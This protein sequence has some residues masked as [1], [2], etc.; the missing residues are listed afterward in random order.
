MTRR[1]WD[2]LV[3]I[4]VILA[5]KVSHEVTHYLAAVGLGERVLAFRFLTNGWG[6]SQ[7][8]YATPV[9]ERAGAYWLVIALAPTLVTVLIGYVIYACRRSLV[10]PG[11]RL[12]SMVAWYGGLVFLLLDP[13]YI[14]VLSLFVGGDVGA[15]AV[16][17]W[18]PWV[19]RAAG[20]ALLAGNG[21][22]VARWVRE[23]LSSGR[24][25]GRQLA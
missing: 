3:W 22:L 15:A 16:V 5:Q 7:V 9:A 12:L 25:S 17:G 20:L 1:W 6:T 11:R 24:P 21:L 14:G 2:I 19:V 13:L 18:S 23:L 10:S 8:L 4:A